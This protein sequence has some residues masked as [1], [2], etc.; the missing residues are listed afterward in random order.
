MLENARFD[1]MI[2]VMTAPRKKIAGQRYEI[3][4][5]QHIARRAHQNNV[6]PQRCRNART[7]TQPF[8]CCD[9]RSSHLPMPPND[10]IFQCHAFFR[11]TQDFKHDIKAGSGLAERPWSTQGGD[12]TPPLLYLEGF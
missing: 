3:C 12:I 9:G 5:R 8:I 2:D 11:W 6:R 1:I 10:L 7:R 4:N